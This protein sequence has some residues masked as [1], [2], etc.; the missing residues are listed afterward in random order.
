MKKARR[1][2]RPEPELEVVESWQEVLRLLVAD[3]KDDDVDDVL[4]AILTPLTNEETS[5]TARPRSVLA[6]RCLADEPNVS[7]EVAQEVLVSFGRA[8]KRGDGMG[9]VR[10]TIDTA[11]IEVG[12]SQWGP[13]P[14][15]CLVEE[16]FRRCS[17]E[18]ANPGGLLGMVQVTVALLEMPLG[19]RNGLKHS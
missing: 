16:F 15:Q 9:R 1:R 6:T 14:Q 12:A 18:R 11:A 19:F 5:K 7:E 13:K 4:R 2:A 8:I 17:N 10:T 3:C